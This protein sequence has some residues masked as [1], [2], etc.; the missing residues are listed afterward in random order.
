MS[1]ETNEIS[2]ESNEPVYLYRFNIGGD[3]YRL[4]QVA[5]EITFAGITYTPTPL[6][7]TALQAAQ[8]FE[9][10]TVT[11]T[12]PQTHD[13][14]QRYLGTPPGQRG[15]V[16]I[17]KVHRNDLGSPAEYKQLFSGYIATITMEGNVECQFKCNPLRNDLR[18]AG[19]RYKYTHLCNHTWGDAR[20]KI[21][22]EDYAFTGTVS[23]VD[24]DVI[25]V[26]GAV[27]GGRADGYFGDGGGY[28]KLAG[29]FG[30]DYRLILSQDGDDQRLL[31]PFTVDVTGLNVRLYA[32]CLHD[33]GTCDTKFSNVEN[34]GGFPYIPS[35]NVFKSELR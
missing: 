13:L 6:R 10:N 30:D 31:L 11:V 23:A 33:I 4:T 3:Q 27:G 18:R 8:E 22:P 15:V 19:P 1:F 9:T 20:C 35:K 26:T 24:G 5:D 16:D 12:I 7:H 25:T 29:P 28:V 14:A 21:D 17:W 2:V 34:F 32:G